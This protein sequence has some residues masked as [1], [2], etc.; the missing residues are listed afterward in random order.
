MDGI[1][2]LWLLWGI[3]IY[4]TFLLRKSHPDRYRYAFMSLVLICV[5]PYGIK[6]GTVEVA[7]PVIVLALICILYIRNFALREKLYMLI[8]VL[9]MGMLYAGIGC[10]S[11]YDPVLMFM[12]RD[13]IISLSFVLVSILF[14]SH[15]SLYR[16]RVIAILGSSVVG[17]IFLSIPLNKIGFSY[18]IGSPAYLD[19]LALSVGLLLVIKIL[20]ELNQIVNLKSQTNKGEM[21]NL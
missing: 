10:L 1:L 6:F 15:S 5:F 12:N 2:Y 9:T 8:A 18:A 19:I 17:D 7:L 4:T 3:W 16:L 13:I 14:Y 11:I 20:G 21:R